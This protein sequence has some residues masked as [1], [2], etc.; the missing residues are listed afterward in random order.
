MNYL[1]DPRSPYNSRNSRRAPHFIA[2]MLRFSICIRISYAY[3]LSARA[4]L[5]KLWNS[6]SRMAVAARYAPSTGANPVGAIS[7]R[8]Y[9]HSL[10]VTCRVVDR[11]AS[12]CPPRMVALSKSRVINIYKLYTPSEGV[13]GFKKVYLCS[14]K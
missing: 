12:P 10:T 8:V 2:R 13:P 9:A 5:P 6:R 1:F 3:L 14:V 7:P 11:L 4:P